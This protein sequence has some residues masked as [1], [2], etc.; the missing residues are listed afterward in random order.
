MLEHDALHVLGRAQHL[1]DVW[2][3]QVGQELDLARERLADRPRGG[4]E[5]LARLRPIQIVIREGYFY[6]PG[7]AG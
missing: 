3:V 2:V 4:R 5:L 6:D 7:R 1:D